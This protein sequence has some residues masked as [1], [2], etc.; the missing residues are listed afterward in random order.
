MRNRNFFQVTKFTLA[1]RKQKREKAKEVVCYVINT[2]YL[3]FVL[4]LKLFIEQKFLENTIKYT[5]ESNVFLKPSSLN[6]QPLQAVMNS[7]YR[8]GERE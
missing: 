5:E 7:G 3:Y 8:H 6:M 2:L 1:L 4:F